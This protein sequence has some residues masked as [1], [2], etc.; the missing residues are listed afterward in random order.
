MLAVQRRLGS[1]SRQWPRKS[2]PS[3]LSFSGMG[4]LW[5]IPTLYMIWKLCSYSCQG[6]CGL[7]SKWEPLF[8]HIFVDKH[9]CWN[10]VVLPQMSPLTFPVTIS[11]RTQPKLQ[12]SAALPWPSPF[13]LVMTSGA[14]YADSDRKYQS[15]H[16]NVLVSDALMIWRSEATIQEGTFA[17]HLGPTTQKWRPLY[18]MWKKILRLIYTSVSSLCH[19]FRYHCEPFKVLCQGWDVLRNS[20]PKQYGCVLWVSTRQTTMTLDS[21]I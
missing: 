2:F 6:L 11:M 1:L 12:I 21:I 8:D 13:A 17:H 9:T 5:P 16:Q 3:V 7:R 20:Q 10:L 4:G 15:Q 14:M 18:P 19:P